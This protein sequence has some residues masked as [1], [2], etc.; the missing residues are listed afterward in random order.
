MDFSLP[1]ED[2]IRTAYQQGEAGVLELFG[3]IG[4]QF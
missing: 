1:T 4:D 3:Q 2:E